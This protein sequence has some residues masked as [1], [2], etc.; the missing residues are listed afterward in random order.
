MGSVVNLIK[1]VNLLEIS[2][3]C[4]KQISDLI[5]Y[6]QVS[7]RGNSREIKI[8]ITKTCEKRVVLNNENNKL[9]I[10]YIFYARIVLHTV[11]DLERS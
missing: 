6:V 9:E 5:C 11:R 2:D 10:T 8:K 3:C 7:Q 4:V 1:S